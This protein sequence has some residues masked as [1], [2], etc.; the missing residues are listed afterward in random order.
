MNFPVSREKYNAAVAE[1]DLLQDQF[2]AAQKELEEAKASLTAAATR[3][4]DLSLEVQQLTE[5]VNPDQQKRIEDLT[6]QLTDANNSISNLEKDVETRTTELANANERITELEQT[7]KTIKE[8]AVDSSA[9]A[10]VD[11]DSIETD[12]YAAVKF[13]QENADDTDACVAKLR[14]LGL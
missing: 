12:P 10:I 8:S 5:M 4:S 7:V 3:E 11:N 13:F 6:Q 14:E 2:A 9:Q 1:R